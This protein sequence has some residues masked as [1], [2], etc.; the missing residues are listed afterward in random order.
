MEKPVPPNPPP[1]GTHQITNEDLAMKRPESPFEMTLSQKLHIERLR[2]DVERAHP[3]DL[4][5]MVVELA[6]QLIIKSNVA[7]AL[8]RGT[9]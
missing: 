3:D 2:R 1:N 5:P 4:R 6:T 9:F 7:N 8:M